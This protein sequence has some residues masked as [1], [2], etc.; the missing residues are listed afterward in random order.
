M[1]LIALG[2][3]G[4]LGARTKVLITDILASTSAIAQIEP[5]S[6]VWGQ[7]IV[8]AAL[9][10]RLELLY[11]MWNPPPPPLPSPSTL[12]LGGIYYVG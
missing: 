1:Y 3:M 12:R 11:L 10:R 2:S 6:T 7:I 5:I 9:A 8:L 4:P